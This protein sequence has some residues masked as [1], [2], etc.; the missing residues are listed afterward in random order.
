MPRRKTVKRVSR[1]RRN[2]MKRKSMRRNTM[3][4][5]TMRRKSM[6]RKSMR[7]KSM[8]RNTKRVNRRK[9][10]SLR[11]RGGADLVSEQP[12]KASWVRVEEHRGDGKDAY[13]ANILRRVRCFL[14][15]P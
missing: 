6:R 2:S 13:S 15:N 10:S 14:K 4:R 11:M 3:R 12:V 1:G 5:N 8:R 7:R 9:R